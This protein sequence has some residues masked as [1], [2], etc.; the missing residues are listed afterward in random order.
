MEDSSTYGSRN[1]SKHTIHASIGQ[2]V[3]DANADD[4]HFTISILHWA[5]RPR[6]VVRNTQRLIQYLELVFAPAKPYVTRRAS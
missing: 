3:S 4:A 2:R 5:C 1:D 6:G